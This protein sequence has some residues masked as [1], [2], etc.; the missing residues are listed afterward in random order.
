MLLYCP[1]CGDILTEGADGRLECAPGRMPLAQELADRFRECY[2]TQTRRPRDV[3]F[4]YRG[5][6]HGIGGEW[7][8][9][10]CGVAAREATP[11][12]LRC[13]ACSQSLVEFIYSLIER[14]PHFDGVSKWR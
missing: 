14:H 6:P 12:D 4:T 10:G 5:Q 8:C 9:P 3:V 7:F 13:P 2:V 11:G 1:K